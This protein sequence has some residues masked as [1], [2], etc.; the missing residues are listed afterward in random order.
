MRHSEPIYTILCVDDEDI[1]L[2]MY[3][4]MIRCISRAINEDIGVE[5]AMSG[6]E[7][8][9]FLESAEVLPNLIL[10]DYLMPDMDGLEAYF[11]I[12]SNPAYNHIS[13]IFTTGYW[14]LAEEIPTEILHDVYILN[15][16]FDLEKLKK[17]IYKYLPIEC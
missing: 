8:L 14:N 3:S 5:L 4:R 6:K 2:K 1:N 9:D 11:H 7:C 12:R 13:V 10:L 17:L 16:P 15:K